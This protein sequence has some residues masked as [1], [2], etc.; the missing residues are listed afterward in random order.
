ME[1]CGEHGNSASDEIAH[2]GRDCPACTQIEE[3]KKD[4]E[5]EVED[6]NNQI[7]DLQT[8]VNTLVDDK[9]ALESEL[10]EAKDNG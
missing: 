1:I 7:E 2:Q 8:E 9:E 4:H 6:L 3:L 5:A 10:E